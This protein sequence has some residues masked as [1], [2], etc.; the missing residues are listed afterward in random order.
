V[1]DALDEG[2]PLAVAV[3]KDGAFGGSD[4]DLV[5]RRGH[6]DASA[7]ITFWRNAPRQISETW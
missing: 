6:L 5:S 1:P 4:D 2:Y 7:P 3:G